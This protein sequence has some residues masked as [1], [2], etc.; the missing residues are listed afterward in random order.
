[1]RSRTCFVSLHDPAVQ[2]ISANYN[3]ATGHCDV[4]VDR[5]VGPMQS[6]GAT[7]EAAALIAAIRI[8]ASSAGLSLQRNAPFLNNLQSFTMPASRGKWL[9]ALL[10][11][12]R[13]PECLSIFQM[14]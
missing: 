5:G 3:P 4:V 12:M 6:T 13:M 1:M 2:E 7:V 8:L 9:R 11:S 10:L 14:T